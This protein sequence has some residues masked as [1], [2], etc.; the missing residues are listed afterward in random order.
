MFDITHKF[1]A[2]VD[3]LALGSTAVDDILPYIRDLQTALLQFPNMP[4]QYS[5][6]ELINNWTE[7]IS[8]MAASDNLTEGDVRQLKLDLDSAC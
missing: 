7:K 1:I 5:G 6:T 2:S 8:G 4:E 3:L